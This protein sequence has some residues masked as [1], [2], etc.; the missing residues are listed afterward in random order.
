MLD[1]LFSKG[2]RTL[3]GSYV[4]TAAMHFLQQSILFAFNLAILWLLYFRPSPFVTIYVYICYFC[5]TQTL[6]VEVTTLSRPSFFTQCP[7]F[8]FA[9]QRAYVTL[10]RYRVF[11][12]NPFGI[13][14]TYIH[15]KDH[16]FLFCLS[17]LLLRI[18]LVLIY[19]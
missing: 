9:A 19:E 7:M 18:R 3:D 13:I 1:L 5:L 17:T 2:V 14:H 6:S 16:R 12:Q 11:S 4:L 8:G 10:L 15:V